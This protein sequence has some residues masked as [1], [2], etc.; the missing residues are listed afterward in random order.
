MLHV[1]SNKGL[2]VQRWVLIGQQL[3]DRTIHPRRGRVELRV[4]EARDGYPW[5][6]VLRQNSMFHTT[7][8]VVGD[9]LNIV[10]IEQNSS[11]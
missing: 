9:Q 3:L 6:S 7:E 11:E 5:R 1:I 4:E 8:P 2:P 10:L